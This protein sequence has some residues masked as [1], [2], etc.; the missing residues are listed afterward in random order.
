MK[1]DATAMDAPEGKAAAFSAKAGTAVKALKRLGFWVQIEAQGKAGWVKASA[2]SFSAG[3]GGPVAIDTGRLG[4]GNIVATSAARGLSAKDLLNG[5]PR[6]DDVQRLAGFA[7][8][9]AAVQ[10]FTAQGSMQAPARAVALVA[11]PVAT[12]VAADTGRTGT[13][14][15]VVTPSMSNATRRKDSDE[16]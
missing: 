10:G 6:P 14:G 16:W 8:D 5:T 12:P 9:V 2:L 4:R 15:R 13:P 3:L 11:P 7:V 1:E